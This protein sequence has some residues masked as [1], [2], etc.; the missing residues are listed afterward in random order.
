MYGASNVTLSNYSNPTQWIL[1][2]MYDLSVAKVSLAYSQTRNGWFNGQTAAD[3]T[4]SAG[5]Y[6]NAVGGVLLDPNFGANSYMVGTTVPLSGTQK[7]FASF[8]YAQPVSSMANAA[9]LSIYSVGYQY[10]LSKRTN[11]YGYI[12]Q[13]NNYAFIQ[14]AQSTV[15]GLGM[16]HSF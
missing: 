9:N 15:Y 10:D 7:L 5:T 11:L 8:Q 4:F 3:S 14:D 6:G 13:A 1:G 16:R 12:S 2:G